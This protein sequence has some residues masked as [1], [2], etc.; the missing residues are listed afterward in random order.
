MT[1]RDFQGMLACATKGAP[2][3]TT[4]PAP[5]SPPAGLSF[6]HSHLAHT[7]PAALCPRARHRKTKNH[8]QHGPKCFSKQKRLRSCPVSPRGEHREIPQR[9]TAG[10]SQPPSTPSPRCRQALSSHS[11]SASRAFAHFSNFSLDLVIP[12]P[13][14]HKCSGQFNQRE[15]HLWTSH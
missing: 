12:L 7:C 4:A 3:P 5:S 9:G 15:T 1:V 2:R 13:R 6:S 8:Q 14:F 10:A 11:S